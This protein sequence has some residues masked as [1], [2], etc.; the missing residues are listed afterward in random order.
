MRL[1]AHD[2]FT[3]PLPRAIDF[4]VCDVACCPSPCAVRTRI[5]ASL[6]WVPIRTSTTASDACRWPW[7]VR[8]SARPAGA[9]CALDAAGIPVCMTLAGGYAERTEDT[10]AINA[11][12]SSFAC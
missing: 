3:S 5:C 2:R 10:V 8:T 9:E 12:V 7:M 4:R 11:T 6:R 1:V